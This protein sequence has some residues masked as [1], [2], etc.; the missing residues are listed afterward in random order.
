MS[1]NQPISISQLS[2]GVKQVLQRSIPQNIWVWGEINTLMVKGGHCYIDLVEKVQGQDALKA[3]IRCNIW[4]WNWRMIAEKFQKATGQSIAQGLTVQLLVQVDY[5]ELYSLSISAV[6]IDPTYTLGSLQ[7][8][9]LQ[10]IESLK[11][12]GLLTLNKRCAIPTL[13][14]RIAVIS[15]AQA[16][17]YTDFCHQLTDNSYGFTYRLEL[18]QSIMQGPKTEESIIDA[19]HRVAARAQ[20]FDIAV[21]I[22]GG[23]A[24]SDLYAFDSLPIAE[25]CAA[26]PLPILTGIGHQRDESILDLVAHTPLK[27]PTAVAEFIIQH[28]KRLADTL[29]SLAKELSVNLKDN[30]RQS[31]SE[32]A[33]LAVRLPAAVQL[34]VN[35][36]RHNLVLISNHFRT[37]TAALLN[38]HKAVAGHTAVRMASASKILL[39]RNN[40]CLKSQA[41]HLPAAI[42][43]LMKNHQSALQLIG[44]KISLQDPQRLLQRGYSITLA[45]GKA[46]TDASQLLPGTVI[47]T[48]VANGEIQSKVTAVTKNTD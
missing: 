48:I 45:D 21:I 17:G 32:L 43:T 6:D 20:E 1:V 26:M 39:S 24:T 47:T 4:Q 37:S 36:T 22:R 18:F 35:N 41:Q 13:L 29:D 42:A 5:H 19:L 2:A 8:R 28:T 27:T 11:S 40:D 25:A 7:R 15:S 12:R 31:T 30:I 44:T 23:G 38:N 16:A 9:R 10:I 46:V 34:L 3:R 33:T 14:K